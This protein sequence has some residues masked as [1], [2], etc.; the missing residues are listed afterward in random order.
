MCKELTFSKYLSLRIY[1]YLPTFQ[2]FY[3]MKMNLFWNISNLHKI[4]SI[5][6]KLVTNV[7]MLDLLFL[8]TG[9][10]IFHMDLI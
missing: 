8:V 6:M 1:G 4:S 5:R 9:S 7:H 3:I 2:V 10:E